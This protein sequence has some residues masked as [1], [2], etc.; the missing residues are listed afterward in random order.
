LAS[1]ESWRADLF[2]RLQELAEEEASLVESDVDVDI[3]RD[4]ETYIDGVVEDEFDYIDHFQRVAIADALPLAGERVG[5]E[6]W[7]SSIAF[8]DVTVT[9]GPSLGN[10]P[11]QVLNQLDWSY[12]ES[13]PRVGGM[14]D[15]ILVFEA[16]YDPN[17]AD[18]ID[19]GLRQMAT[20]VIGEPLSRLL[21]PIGQGPHRVAQRKR[22]RDIGWQAGPKAA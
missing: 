9:V 7:M 20:E 5:I 15:V 6:L 4:V 8:Y 11:D 10:A 3:D 2:S 19:L 21:S 17:S 22:E 12:S 13:S 18:L 14:A 16:I 1:D